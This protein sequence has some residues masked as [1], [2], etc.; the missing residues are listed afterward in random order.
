MEYIRS[1]YS[2]NV[3]QKNIELLN[4]SPRLAVKLSLS[5]QMQ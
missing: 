3:L 4:I 2:V 5:P 1:A